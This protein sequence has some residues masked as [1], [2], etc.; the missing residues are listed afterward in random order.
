MNGVTYREASFLVKRRSG[1]TVTDP[2]TSKKCLRL[3]EESNRRP[4]LEGVK[5]L[6]STVFV[7]PKNRSHK[8]ARERKMDTPKCM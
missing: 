5:V 3:L 6:Q 1:L 2:S 4:M 7:G 8:S